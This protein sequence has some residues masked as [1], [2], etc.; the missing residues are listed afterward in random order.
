MKRSLEDRLKVRI[1]RSPCDVF[2]TRDF[3]DLGSRSQVAR[4]LRKLVAQNMLL[5]LGVGVFAR[6]RPSRISG[7]PVLANSGGFEVVVQQAL[8][9][10]GVTWLPTEAQRA[11]ADGRSTQ[12]PVNPVL[13]VVG[14]FTRKLRCGDYEL[15]LER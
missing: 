3:R 13:K 8:T 15:R 11:Y 10:L 7:R 2:L 9:R 5:R 1:A 4:G 14:R 12:V 6:A